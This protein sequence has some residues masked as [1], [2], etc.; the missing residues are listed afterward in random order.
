MEMS[1]LA[2]LL[3]VRADEGLYQGKDIR[4]RVETRDTE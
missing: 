4:N 1:K 2:I 3:L